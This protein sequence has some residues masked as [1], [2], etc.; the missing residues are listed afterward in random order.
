[1]SK[2]PK[3]VHVVYGWP[4]VPWGPATIAWYLKWEITSNWVISSALQISHYSLLCGIV[5]SWNFNSS[6]CDFCLN[7]YNCTLLATLQVRQSETFSAVLNI[8][9][10]FII[11]S[12]CSKEHNANPKKS[13][14]FSNFCCHA[15]SLLISTTLTLL[16]IAVVCCWLVL[17]HLCF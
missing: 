12:I 17:R 14:F 10:Y 16:N 9:Y 4:L 13:L 5:F 11:Y 1:M 6:Q 15:I 2:N 3:S 7:V 8:K